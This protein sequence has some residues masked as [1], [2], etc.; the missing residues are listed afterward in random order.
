MFFFSKYFKMKKMSVVY[1]ATDLYSFLVMNKKR[2]KSQMQCNSFFIQVSNVDKRENKTLFYTQQYKCQYLRHY[3]LK[4]YK[5]KIHALKKNSVTGGDE[6]YSNSCFNSVVGIFLSHLAS[7]HV[8]TLP[9]HEVH[10]HILYLGV[11]VLFLPL[12]TSEEGISF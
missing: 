11:L 2:M 5:S 1:L 8:S 12:Q 4:Q 7:K 9:K 6:I 3:I 10:S